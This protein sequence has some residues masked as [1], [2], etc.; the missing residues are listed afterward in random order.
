M[1]L[2]EIL[3]GTTVLFALLFAY[4]VVV[5]RRLSR[6]VGLMVANYKSDSEVMAMTLSRV[7]PFLPPV[8]IQ[9]EGDASE[10]IAPRTPKAPAE[11]AYR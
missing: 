11:M 6:Q 9:Q 8:S 1:V 10:E 4:S 2:A 7:V 3:F 5:N